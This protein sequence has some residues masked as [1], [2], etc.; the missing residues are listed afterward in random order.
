MTKPRCDLSIPAAL[1]LAVARVRRTARTIKHKRLGYAFRR[2]SPTPRLERKATY[3]HALANGHPMSKLLF[4][5]V[6]P[7]KAFLESGSMCSV[8]YR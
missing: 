4:C 7:S 3:Q 1:L 2:F 5:F 6:E 8:E